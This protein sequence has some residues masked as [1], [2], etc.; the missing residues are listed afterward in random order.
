M[1]PGV[2]HLDRGCRGPLIGPP[3]SG[4]MLPQRQPTPPCPGVQ[5]LRSSVGHRLHR[6]GL[7]GDAAR[8]GML[9]ATGDEAREHVGGHGRVLIQD[10]H[11]LGPLREGPLDAAVA[12]T[13][14]AQV[15][16]VAEHVE[17]R[18]SCRRPC[19][20]VVGRR[21]IDDGDPCGRELARQQRL[22]TGRQIV[23]AIVRRDDHVH[24]VDVA[25]ARRLEG[26][27]C[28]HACPVRKSDV[29]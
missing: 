11:V 12:G 13:S 22:E 17:A 2:V 6:Q 29:S 19:D 15:A 16:L 26:C 21:V 20:R 24:R 23:S 7:G 8:R 28:R 9:V 27:A 3:D 10:E 25:R 4:D 14:E 5:E 18:K 1:A